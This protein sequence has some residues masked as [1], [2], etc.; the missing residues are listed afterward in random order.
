M[1]TRDR[2]FL[3]ERL[4]SQKRQGPDLDS[5]ESR[6][7]E[8]AAVAR[9]DD[10]I[11]LIIIGH[12]CE[13]S[14]R[15][16]CRGAFAL[17][18]YESVTVLFEEV[19]VGTSQAGSPVVEDQRLSPMRSVIFHGQSVVQRPLQ[20]GAWRVCADLRPEVLARVG[21]FLCESLAWCYPGCPDQVL[22]RPWR[23]TLEVQGEGKLLGAT[24]PIDFNN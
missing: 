9:R 13:R 23:R 5:A 21:V 11:E 7:V 24:L 3:T 10:S 4:L 18:C 1:E 16:G 6:A 15:T 22:T 20:A 2:L 8:A 19:P 17:A 12:A 14:S